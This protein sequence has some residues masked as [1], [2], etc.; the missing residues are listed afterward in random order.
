MVSEECDLEIWLYAATP[1]ACRQS[2]GLM[3]VNDPLPTAYARG[4]EEIP[5]LRAWILSRSLDS[6]FVPFT[7]STKKNGVDG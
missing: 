7:K 2:T 1:I 6:Q 4:L 3:I 5:A